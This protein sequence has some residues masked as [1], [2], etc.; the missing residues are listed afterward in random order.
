MTDVKETLDA[1]EGRV[2]SGLS[3]LLML[4]F[5]SKYSMFVSSI[6]M[7]HSRWDHLEIVQLPLKIAYDSP[8]DSRAL[9]MTCFMSL[10][11]SP[12]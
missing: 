11:R 4:L 12:T 10:L 6:P 7:L 8:F 5:V 2:G 1:F 9:V 3:F